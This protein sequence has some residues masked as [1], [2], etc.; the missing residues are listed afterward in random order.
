MAGPVISKVGKK[1]TWDSN[2]GTL[3]QKVS[4]SGDVALFKSTTCLANG[5][6]DLWTL[7]DC[8]YEDIS[9]GKIHDMGEIR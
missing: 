5:A 1:L 4:T 3:W 9:N 8:C 6:S 2:L 7:R